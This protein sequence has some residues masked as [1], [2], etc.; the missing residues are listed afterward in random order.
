MLQRK[1]WL[2]KLLAG[3]YVIAATSVLIGA[4]SAG[5]A[6]AATAPIGSGNGLRVS[7]V[8]TDITIT[9][10]QSQTISV[11]VTNV[12]GGAT[13]LQAIINDF[14]ANPNES[15][16]PAIILDPSQYAANHSL[17][18]FVASLPNVTLQPGDKRQYRLLLKSHL[19]LPVV[20]TM[21]RCV[22]PRLALLERLRLT[23][24][25]V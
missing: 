12:T 20:A 18:R 3:L 4:T 2:A 16:D 22:L 21:V 6:A 8:R 23:W 9:P 7:P 10:G 14:T 11:N 19:A 24:R 25:V 13:N 15:G 5:K 1:P 17:K